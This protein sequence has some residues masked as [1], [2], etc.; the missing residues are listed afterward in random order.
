MAGTSAWRSALAALAAAALLG[1]REDIVAP[2][3][4]PSLCPSAD[5]VLMDTT[6]TGV[7]ASDTSIRGFVAPREAAILVA[8][9]LDS[10]N[11]LVVVRFSPLDTVFR[12]SGDTTAV[13]IGSYDSVTIN[14]TMQQ[15][16]TAAKDLRVLLVRLPAG[17]DTTATYATVLP[18]FADS[19]IVDSIVVADS[20]LASTLHQSLPVARLVPQAGDSGT[21]ALGIA[22]RAASPTAVSFGAVDVSG[23]PPRLTYFARGAGPKDTLTQAMSRSPAFDTFVMTP[24]PGAP[25]AGT[26]EVGNL[27]SARTLLRL[28]IPRALLDSTSVVRG[29]L[30]LTLTR[31][32]TGRPREAF[33][34]EARP[35]IR[36][37]G[38]KSITTTDTV[39]VGR[40]HVTVGQSGTVEVEIGRILSFWGKPAADSLP[41]AILLR[42]R[43]ELTT[44]GEVSFAGRAA[45]AAAPVLRLTVVRPY[46]FGVP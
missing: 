39:V 19:L 2:G 9:T 16:D 17:T 10:M 7:V 14:L 22:I 35:V 36:D 26:L 31:P 29:T 34:I 1:C 12:V 6:L 40:G 18:F 24:L 4:C 44:L 46:A 20:V 3:Q 42:S 21:V 23:V 38:G 28:D 13:P 33:D 11:S 37:F 5:V 45:G 15:R 27:P 8:S 43:A 41:R 30:V 32:V 25:P